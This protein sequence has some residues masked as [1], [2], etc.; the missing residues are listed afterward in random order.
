MDC[1]VQAPKRLLQTLFLKGISEL[2]RPRK[3]VPH[4]PFS[5]ARSF[6]PTG[7][8]SRVV[9]P[10]GRSLSNALD[11]LWPEHLLLT[12][13]HKTPTLKESATQDFAWLRGPVALFRYL[14]LSLTQFLTTPALVCPTRRSTC[15]TLYQFH[16]F[17]LFCDRDTFPP[18]QGTRLPFSPN[19]TLNP[20]FTQAHV[21]V[22]VGITGTKQEDPFFLEPQRINKLS[23]ETPLDPREITITITLPIHPR[24]RHPNFIPDTLI[25]SLFCETL[26][27]TACRFPLTEDE[28]GSP[29]NKGIRAFPRVSGPFI[30]TLYIDRYLPLSTRR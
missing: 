4:N 27:Q 17:F 30:Y 5:F 28:R 29:V 18:S 1:L 14:L 24:P 20:H 8:P 13:K 9:F 23:A 21:R 2:E 3:L 26:S 10:H 6:P 19:W 15:G 7:L 11:D 22:A 25:T 12:V 16:S